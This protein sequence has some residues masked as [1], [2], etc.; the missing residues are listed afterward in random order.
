MS[1]AALNPLGMFVFNDLLFVLITSAI[2][3]LESLDSNISAATVTTI[4]MIVTNPD[5]KDDIDAFFE[6]KLRNP[7]PA[8]KQNCIVC[9]YA[10]H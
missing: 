6:P 8:A 2:V 10:R 5:A 3:G 7:P 9:T 1:V 4:A